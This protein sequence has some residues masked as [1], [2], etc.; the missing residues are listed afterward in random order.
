MWARWDSEWYLLI[1]DKGY[2]SYES[3]QE[4]GHGKYLPQDAT[5]FFPAYPMAIKALTYATRNSVLSGWILSNLA[6][7]LFLYFFYNLSS[8]LIDK[9]AAFGASLFYIFYPTSF[10]LNAV[11]SESL[12]LAALLAAFYFVEKKHLFAA[13]IAI[14]I[15]TLTR[16]QGLLALPALVWVAWRAFPQRKIPAA[17]IVLLSGV[18]PF[19]AYSFYLHTKFGSGLWFAL[20]QNYWRGESRFPLYGI[21]RFFQSDIAIHGQHN[22]MI[23]FSFAMLHLVIL[24]LSLSKITAPYWIYSLLILFVP[25]SSSLFSFSRLSLVNFPLFLYL[26]GKVTGRWS[27]GLLTLFAMLLA[28][29]MAAFANWFWVG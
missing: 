24:V 21:V 23:D 4:A 25:L 20:S 11:Y 10:F 28:F 5:K 26:G 13:C 19:A 3:F 18:V 27:F 12:F 17:L 7:V 15:A 29:F 14:A 6:S 8:H 16:P 1:A 22:S 9:E 2:A